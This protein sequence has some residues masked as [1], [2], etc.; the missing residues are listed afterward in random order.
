MPQRFE[1]KKGELILGTRLKYVLETEQI[2]PGIRRAIFD[3]Q[4]GNYFITEVRRVVNKTTKSCGCLR[5]ETTTRLKTKH[6]HNTKGNMSGTYRAYVSMKCRVSCRE[7][8]K[9]VEICDRWLGENGFLNFLEDMGERPP[10]PN[11][12]LE[13]LENSRGYCKENCRWASQAEQTRNT[14][15]NVR[16]TF[17][18]V[19]KILAEWCRHFNIPYHVAI[20]R[21]NKLGWSWEETFKT[22]YIDSK[23]QRHRPFKNLS[24]K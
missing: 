4:C 20:D 19:T 13:R 2:V 16:L 6:G 12:T 3:C 23:Q 18:G 14:N 5:R 24:T 10:F 22:P 15:R 1:H 7:H 9:N 21:H 8:Y 17:S 11:N